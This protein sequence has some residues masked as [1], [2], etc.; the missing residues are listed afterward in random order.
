MSRGE[1]SRGETSCYHYDYDD[2]D[3]YYY[4]YQ[5]GYVFA[6][7]Y[8]LVGLSVSRVTQRKLRTNVH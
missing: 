8:L 4:L 6:S 5:K 2:D 1:M 7:V 3:Y